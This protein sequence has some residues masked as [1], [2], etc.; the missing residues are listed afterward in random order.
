MDV[1][2]KFGEHEIPLTNRVRGPSSR[3]FFARIYD[4]S[5]KRAGAINRVEKTRLAF[6]RS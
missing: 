5:T 4:S 2:G 1:S 3:V 6:T